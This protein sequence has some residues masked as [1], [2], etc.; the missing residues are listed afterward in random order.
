MNNFLV[1]VS[2]FGKSSNLLSPRGYGPGSMGV[3]V[4]VGVGAVGGNTVSPSTYS[5]MNNAAAAA[6]LGMN[7]YHNGGAAAAAAAMNPQAAF[8]NPA[9]HPCKSTCSQLLPFVSYM[10]GFQKLKTIFLYKAF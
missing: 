7:S 9:A 3:G 1:F 8:L 6:T 2:G 5:S 4:G 10:N